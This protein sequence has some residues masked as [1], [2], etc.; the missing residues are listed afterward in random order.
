MTA[1]APDWSLRPVADDD[2]A[3]LH[4][5][6]C[7]PQVYRYLAD[8]AAP[9]RSAV[10][11]WIARSHAD[12]SASGVGL[13][14]LEDGRAYLDGLGGCV[15]LEAQPELRSAELMY[16]LHP[17]HW[18]AGLATRMSWTVMELALQGGRIDRIV[19]GTDAPNTASVA[20][21][22]RLGMTLLR[23][24]H[25][26]AGPGVEYVFRRGAPAPAPLPQPIP[27]RRAGPPP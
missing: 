26:P 1:H 12:F 3:A 18:G 17:R 20:V 15:R 8:G 16:V 23:D 5:V 7:V 10:E 6:L 14:V 11:G 25:Y 9:P 27:V 21:M 24:V 19:A 4:A 22:R 13:W 2:T